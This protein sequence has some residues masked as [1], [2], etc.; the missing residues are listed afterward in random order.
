LKAKLTFNLPEDEWNHKRAL[1]GADLYYAVTSF[2]NR[3]KN[4][5]KH[6]DYA[7]DTHQEIYD[8]FLQE[9]SDNDITLD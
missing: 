8:M 4:I 1:E 5:L 6:D 9:L 3:L 2:K 7:T